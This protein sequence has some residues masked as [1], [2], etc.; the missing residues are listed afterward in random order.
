MNTPLRRA[1]VPCVLCGLLSFAGALGCKKSESP[2]DVADAPVETEEQATE[3]AAHFS[4]TFRHVS[5]LHGEETVTELELGEDMLQQRRN[6][7]IVFDAPCE[8][9]ADT[10]RRMSF[11]CT[12]DEDEQT[13]WP[14]EIDEEGKLF[15]R[16]MPEM[17]YERVE[18]ETP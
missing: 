8:K 15:H 6:G 14:L 9:T 3:V 1:V 4:G 13:L 10:R 2:E 16:A 11:R 7:L 12:L 5:P 17:R 18:I